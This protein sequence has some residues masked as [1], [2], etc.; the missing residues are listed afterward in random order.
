MERKNIVVGIKLWGKLRK[1]CKTC[2]VFPILSNSSVVNCLR[3]LF[4]KKNK[5]LEGALS[6]LMDLNKSPLEENAYHWS[7]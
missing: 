4:K 6:Y 7:C 2:W 3:V 5:N 1:T